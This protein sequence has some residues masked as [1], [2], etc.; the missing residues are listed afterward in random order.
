MNY[1]INAGATASKDHNSSNSAAG[2]TY[3]DSIASTN[4]LSLGNTPFST[5]KPRIDNFLGSINHIPN[6]ARNIS[7]KQEVLDDSIPVPLTQHPK[8]KQQSFI[9][10]RFFFKPKPVYLNLNFDRKTLV[11]DFPSYVFFLKMK[12]ILQLMSKDT[13]VEQ[14]RDYE[15]DIFNKIQK[16]KSIDLTEKRHRNQQFMVRQVLHDDAIAKLRKCL[17]FF[18][19]KGYTQRDVE[20]RESFL[21]VEKEIRKF[22][23]NQV[24]LYF[25]KNASKII[26]LLPL[27][28]KF[29]MQK[30]IR[31]W[32][33]RLQ[34]NQRKRDMLSKLSRY[35]NEYKLKRHAYLKRKFIFNGRK[36]YNY[37]VN[38]YSTELLA[39]NVKKVVKKCIRKW[40]Y[41]TRLNR[42]KTKF[43]VFRMTLLLMKTLKK[44]NNVS[45]RKQQLWNNIVNSFI[46]YRCVKRWKR[47]P[48]VKNM[49]VAKRK[50]EQN[51]LKHTFQKLKQGHFLKKRENTIKR[52]VLD[53]FRHYFVAEMKK[54]ERSVCLETMADAF[55]LR[56][57][58]LFVGRPLP[59]NDI[60][61]SL[62]RLPSLE[63][64]QPEFRDLAPYV[65]LEY[66]RTLLTR[67][68]LSWRLAFRE[69]IFCREKLLSN[70]VK[71]VKLWRSQAHESLVE[72]QSMMSTDTIQRAHDLLA[73]I[74]SERDL[75]IDNISDF[76]NSTLP[77]FST[78]EDT[79]RNLRIGNRPTTSQR[80]MSDM[81][82][83]YQ[84]AH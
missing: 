61:L 40:R 53:S 57:L 50:Y 71:G 24:Y 74:G 66:Y 34:K 5:S 17:F 14:L 69:R 39:S 22:Q 12:T 82:S 29:V 18:T 67:S 73:H 27:K 65:F 26:K 76:L 48:L 70:L 19:L 33:E 9:I 42:R 77:F 38:G 75:S 6:F 55:Y 63:K 43:I 45:R 49:V 1:S 59:L 79:P 83:M 81:W 23:R 60:L 58:I 64:T 3:Y 80:L 35:E 47:H 62:D 52:R 56:R 78:V 21:N 25:Q 20:I 30:G 28:N 11:R 4:S 36:V 51:V 10:P 72:K 7:R 32:R 68:I 37:D 8:T 44:W 41:F 13:L 2:R 31:K 54:N 46:V 16:F 15:I 84:H